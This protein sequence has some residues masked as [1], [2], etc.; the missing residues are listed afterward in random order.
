MR[1][2]RAPGRGRPRH[3]VAMMLGDRTVSRHDRGSLRLRSVNLYAAANGSAP[4]LRRLPVQASRR[5]GGRRR[6]TTRSPLKR[7][8]VQAGAAPDGEPTPPHCGRAT[9][10]S[11][12]RAARSGRSDGRR[13]A[14]V[15]GGNE[16]QAP[17]TITRLEP[18]D[19]VIL[20]AHGTG[21][22]GTKPSPCC[23]DRDHLACNDTS[24][25]PR[26]PGAEA[27]GRAVIERC[28]G[29]HRSAPRRDEFVGSSNRSATTAR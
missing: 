27:A 12:P 19:D 24:A 7:V 6:L 29:R 17:T 21:Q 16:P 8:D 20:P 13:N 9:E 1:R 28:V 22:R 18:G 26:R 11:A 25:T 4:E 3:V 23:H 15:A 5:C 14:E 2:R 10:N